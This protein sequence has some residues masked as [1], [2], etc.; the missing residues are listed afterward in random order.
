MP[1]VWQHLYKLADGTEVGYSHKARLGFWN[2]V[3]PGPT[4][5]RVQKATRHDARGKT[6]PP[7][8]HDDA[9]KAIRQSYTLT[10]PSLERKGWDELLDEVDRTS[11]TTKPETLRSFRAAAKALREIMPEVHSPL[12]ISDDRVRRFGKLFLAKPKANGRKKSPATL[13]YYQRALSAFSNHLVDLGHLNRNPWKGA[14]VPKGERRKKP[15]QTEAQIGQFMAHVK[16]RYPKWTA[17]HAMLDLKAVTASRTADLCQLRTSELVR[18]RLVFGADITKTNTERGIQLPPDLYQTLTA[19]AGPTY[20]WE[21]QFWDGIREYRKQSNGLPPAFTWK[22]VYTV[23]NNIF[24]EYNVAHPGQPKLTP[25]ALRRRA[26]TRAVVALN[27]NTDAVANL[28]G[29]NPQTARTAYLD[30]QQAFDADRDAAAV[31]DRLRLPP[32]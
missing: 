18:G 31:L 3:Y 4:G 19:V 2:V 28:F 29:V 10:L 21:G 24:K 23:L 9:Q 17:L 5:K 6:P 1:R 26:I 15:A 22:T 25:H 13:S 27:G 8:W 32:T 14:P 7:D 16:A 12:D 30:Y 11:P 20:L